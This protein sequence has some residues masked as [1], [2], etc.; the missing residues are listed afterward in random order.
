MTATDLLLAAVLLGAPA[1]TPEPLPPEDRWPA[2]RD[3]VHKLALEWEIMDPR[4]TRY[5]FAN[6]ADFAADLN[7]LRKRAADLADAPKLAACARL[8]ERRAVNELVKW[9]REYRRQL[10]ARQ[11]W[12]ADRA[13]VLHAAIREAD[14]LY[15]PWDAL[16]DAQCD[17]Y[18]VTVRR[19]AL[20]KL[21]DALGAEA[22]ATGRM[23]DAV[24]EGRVV[25]R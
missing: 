15:L 19:T 10:E 13:D 4:E 7:L 1:D 21:R 12:E 9:N 24:P 5:V 22:F 6:R 2:L 11:A 20:K 25:A 14:H 23:P 18:Y 16:R 3:A 8:P 17:F